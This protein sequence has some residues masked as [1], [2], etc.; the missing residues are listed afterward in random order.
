MPKTLP[1]HI[2]TPEPARRRFLRTVAGGLLGT[3]ASL[4]IGHGVSAVS[5]WT[6]QN[7]NSVL[8]QA[9]PTAGKNDLRITKVD[10]YIVRFSKDA[11]GALAGN[12]CV[13]CRIETADGMWAGARG[14]TSRR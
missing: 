2:N 13:L 9:K 3:G 10:P 12:Y 1:F 11:S 14:R 5:A 6:G 8:N 4:K 7:T